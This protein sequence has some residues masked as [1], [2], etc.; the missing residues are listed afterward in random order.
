MKFNKPNY[1]LRTVRIP[2]FQENRQEL[3]F[4]S[5]CEEFNFLIRKNRTHA[6][7]MHTPKSTLHFHLTALSNFSLIND[8]LLRKLHNLQPVPPLSIASKATII[9]F[10]FICNPAIVSFLLKP[11]HSGFKP[12][13]F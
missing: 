11:E 4:L 9:V 1:S 8:V 6:A 12:R 5:V 7:V 3:L 10:P 13:V 2:I